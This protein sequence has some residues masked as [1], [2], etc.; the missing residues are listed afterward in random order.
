M[1]KNILHQVCLES[2]RPRKDKSFTLTFST[3]EL[4]S[5]DVLSISELHGK[6]GIMYFADKDTVSAEELAELDKVDIELEKKSYGQR[7]RHV[8]YRIHEQ[9]GGNDSNV[10]AFYEQKMEAIIT[11]IKSKLD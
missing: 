2:Y 11:Q 10:K 4:Q 8:L 7:L 5:D 9:N 1:S 3:N 6:M